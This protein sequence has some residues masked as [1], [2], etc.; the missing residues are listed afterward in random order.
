MAQIWEKDIETF[1]ATGGK[2]NMKDTAQEKP[3]DV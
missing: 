3:H 2:V 1:I